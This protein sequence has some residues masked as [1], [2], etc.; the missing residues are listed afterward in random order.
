MDDPAAPP[1]EAGEELRSSPFPEGP[2]AS[3]QFPHFAVALR[4]RDFRLFWGGN[5]LSNIGTWMQNVAQGWLVLQLTNSAFWLGVVGFASTIP[6]LLF[7]LVGGALRLLGRPFP[8]RLAIAAAAMGGALLV[9]YFVTSALFHPSNPTVALNQGFNKFDYINPIWLLATLALFPTLAAL[10]LLLLAP[11]LEAAAARWR[12]APAA[13]V[14]IAGLGLWFA[15]AGTGPLT[16]LYARHTAS[17]VLALALAL[18]LVSPAAWLVAARRPL[19]LYAAITALAAVS[20]NVD[21]F[22]FGRFVDNHVRPGVTDVDAPAA[23]WPARFSEPYGERSY[24]KWGAGR[25][26]QRDVVVP[27]YDWY[28]VT[29]AFYSFFRSDRESVLFH[30]LGRPGDW[31]PFECAALDR[32]RPRAHDAGDRM[33]LDFLSDRYCVR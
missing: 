31:I 24:L 30:P 17:H 20:Y 19:M 28:Q 13:I 14:I 1:A 9:A 32:A 33:F 29:L 12:L 27:L 7:A 22:L 8:P 10:W 26:Y 6:F 4:H 16:W 5:F 18:A 23:A 15:A 11:G 21:L 2:E 25:D 3:T